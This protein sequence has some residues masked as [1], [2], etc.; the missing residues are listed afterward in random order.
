VWQ[1]PDAT[2]RT[3]ASPGLGASIST[4]VTESGVHSFSKTAALARMAG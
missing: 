1:T 3:S 4:S 2:I